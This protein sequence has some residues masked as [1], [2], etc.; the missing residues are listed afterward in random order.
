MH[1]RS[2]EFNLFAKLPSFPT[3]LLVPALSH[4]SKR[5]SPG[6]ANVSIKSDFVRNFREAIPNSPKSSKIILR[7]LTKLKITSS[8][9]KSS[10]ICSSRSPRSVLVDLNV[11]G[12]HPIF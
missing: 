8:S 6:A 10:A 12:T 7:K 4:A 1:G 2:K 5:S 11:C 9:I 3:K